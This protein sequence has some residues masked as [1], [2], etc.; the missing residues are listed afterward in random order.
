M[1][2]LVADLAIADR[3]APDGVSR[4]ADLAAACAVSVEPL[5]RV[6]RALAAFGIFRLEPGDAI[7][8]TPRSRLLR[9]DTP[10]S[11]HY[12]ARF[13]TAQASWRAWEALD[14]ALL[15][16]VPH[17]VA[18]GAG[19][20]AYLRDH[21]DE[22]R[23]FDSYMAHGP[24]DRHDAIAKAYDFSQASLI[25]D[26]GGG[27]G[28]ALR[29]ILARHPKARGLVFDR[30]DVVAAIPADKRAEGRLA[31]QGGSFFEGVPA[32]ADLYLLVHVLHDWSDEQALEILRSCR[33]A[34]KPQARL[35]IIEL[36][37]GSDPSQSRHADYLMD[38][39]MMAMFGSACERTAAEFEELLAAANLQ[40]A[41]I[42]PTDASVSIL[43]AVP[44]A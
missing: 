39:Q 35:L 36:M 6:L 33:A 13:W 22:A 32:G 24:E 7:A 26:I 27:N 15:D 11:L 1:I 4:I 8:H 21:P 12:G 38:M 34:M 31:T 5:K 20:F 3:V 25:A 16:K 9:T 18:W 40:I 10:R 42:I 29:R 43:E 30:P 41:S 17:E 2:R 14:A 28:E 19:R 23:L 44:V 37:L